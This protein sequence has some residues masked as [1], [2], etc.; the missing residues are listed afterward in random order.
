M[1][2]STYSSSD[3]KAATVI[4]DLAIEGVAKLQFGTKFALVPLVRAHRK[5]PILS[6]ICQ[7]AMRS[8]QGHNHQILPPKRVLQLPPYIGRS[9][10][11]SHI[12]QKNYFTI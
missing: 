5:L 6:R 12:S 11:Y 9:T 3:A 7:F 8:N 4:A 10:V 1:A 2:N